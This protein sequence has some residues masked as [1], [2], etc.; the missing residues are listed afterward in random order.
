MNLAH[1]LLTQ[2][3]IRLKHERIG[4]QKTIC[5][6]C[7]HLRHDKKDPCLSVTIKPDYSVFWNCHNCISFKGAYNVKTEASRINQQYQKKQ[8]QK[9]KRILPKVQKYPQEFID[10]FEK[11]GISIS[12]VESFDITLAMLKDIGACAVFPY[13]RDGEVI[14][15]KYRALTLSEKGK[16]K[17]RQEIDAEPT[18]W[19][20]DKC[21][22][23][24]HSVIIVEGEMDVLALHQAGIRNVW[25]VPAGAPAEENG[26]GSK[27]DFLANCEEYL[28][29]KT[30]VTLAVD[31]D[32][33][34]QVLEREL[35]RRIGAHRC[36]K[37]DWP[38]GCKDANDVLM[39]YGA[40]PL[41]NIIL[42]S[43]KYPITGL[44]EAG[45]YLKSVRD[46]YEGK[47]AKLLTT[48]L[49][50]V[51]EVVKF[52][53]GELSVVTGN[54]GSGKSEFLDMI[55]VNMARLHGWKFAICSFE[56]PPDRHIL[57]YAEKYVGKPANRDLRGCM[58]WEELRDCITQ[59]INQHFFFIEAREE[60]PDHEWILE[61]ARIAVLRY[62][63]KGLI[64]DPYNEIDHK[65]EKGES[66]TDYVSK[67][68][69]K[70]KRFAHN[71]GVHVWIVAHPVKPAH[72][73][74]NKPRVPHLYDCAGSANWN[75]KA[76]VGLVVHSDKKTNPGRTEI[77]VVKIRFKEV[78][79]VGTRVLAYDK[80]TGI[81]SDLP[82]E[83]SY[84]LLN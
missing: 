78:G 23:D 50:T 2:H 45:D 16:K 54:P 36:W 80:D 10:L 19:G 57:K 74:D 22:K 24:A 35:A 82:D 61:M 34:G 9:P 43:R 20:L 39:Q 17:F 44:Y 60:T 51:D 30:T 69:N 62:G 15:Y 38:D 32:H 83:P 12:T 37:V 66:E 42:N 76:D 13:Y 70:F 40:V 47:T 3:G 6:K 4:N 8:Y 11:R 41:Q 29:N 25:S 28:K 46:I 58:K 18:F 81:Y 67:I 14:N 55:A 59:N 56:N 84:Q 64:V 48:G 21:G 63:V 33:N 73:A 31:N 49:D 75:N 77:H 72:T 68:L 79:Q 53:E 52:R 26:D 65:R 71:Y 27:F 5:P 1:D 7:S